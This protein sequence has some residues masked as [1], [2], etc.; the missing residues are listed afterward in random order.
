MLQKDGLIYQLV[1]QHL[2]MKKKSVKLKASCS[3]TS[4][5]ASKENTQ[6]EHLYYMTLQDVSPDSLI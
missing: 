5:R 4:Q 3:L 2:E 1:N 6:R